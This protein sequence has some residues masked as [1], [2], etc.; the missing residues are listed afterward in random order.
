MQILSAQLD[1][2]LIVLIRSL[3]AE[4][5]GEEKD[6]RHGHCLI[7]PEELLLLTSVIAP[8]DL[9]NEALEWCASYHH[10]ISISRLRALVKTGGSSIEEPF[11]LFAATLNSISNADWPLFIEKDP[12]KFETSTTPAPPQCERPS[13]LYLRLRTLFGVGARADLMTFFLTQGKND[14]TASDTAE[15][16]YGK[17]SLA[18]LLIDF[19]QSGFFTAFTVGNQRRFRFV[20]QDQ[21]IAILGKIPEVIPPWRHILEVVLPL[22]TCILQVE[23]N[24]QAIKTAELHKVLLQM[25]DKLHRLYLTPPTANSDW[26][27]LSDWILNIVKSYSQGNFKQNL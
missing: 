5:R 2:Y 8:P 17:R 18:D 23:E 7:A 27:F 1:H 13:L 12:L 4:F 9:Q 3:W 11:S 20:K 6:R 16:G 10:F 14:F 19:V 22:R 25:H 24:P 26:D 21:M 15:L